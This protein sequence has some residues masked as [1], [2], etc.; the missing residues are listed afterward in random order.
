[1]KKIIYSALVVLL[2][3]TAIQAQNFDE[4][5][6]VTL[7][8][9]ETNVTAG[10]SMEKE[11]PNT[12]AT[13][14][15]M[16]KVFYL[17]A[18]RADLTEEK[19]K[20]LLKIIDERNKVLKDL[21]TKKKQANATFSIEEPGTFFNF[22]IK[23]A[24]NF[25]ARKISELITYKQYCYFVVDNYREEAVRK[26]TQE[27]SQLIKNNPDLIK[28]QK[29][30][31]FKIIYNFHLNQLMTSAYLSFDTYLQK[32]KLGVLRFN[33][34]KEFAKTCKELNIKTAESNESN[35]NDFQWN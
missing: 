32:P 16:E 30:K 7:P 22:K 34:E 17:N 5:K 20:A 29:I 26:A 21:D 23:E 27:Y 28:E 2:S 18:K 33:F 4:S 25:Y 11:L 35:K 12:N 3:T 31:L 13:A 10:K 9:E 19:S 24:R 1:M 15:A 14:A 8:D 6:N